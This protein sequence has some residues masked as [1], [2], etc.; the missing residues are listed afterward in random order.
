[1]Q[2]ECGWKCMQCVAAP[3]HLMY[4]WLRLCPSCV[5][6]LGVGRQVKGVWW[7]NAWCVA[8]FPGFD[9]LWIHRCEENEDELERRGCPLKKKEGKK[10][11][12]NW[13]ILSICLIF[14]FYLPF[15]CCFIF[16]LH[17]FLPLSVSCQ[18]SNGVFEVNSRFTE[19]FWTNGRA[20]AFVV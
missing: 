10:K 5:R 15:L 4:F 16:P 17:L 6:L 20:G 18:E 1:M 8:Y 2:N 14:S 12:I 13:W 9:L 7:Q 3:L 11:E 19:R